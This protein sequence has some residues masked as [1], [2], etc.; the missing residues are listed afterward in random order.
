MDAR[1]YIIILGC[2]VLVAGCASNPEVV[3]DPLKSQIDTQVTFQEILQQPETFQGKLVVVGGEVLHAKRSTEATQLE[4]LQLP[5]DDS[6]RPSK[7]KTES[8]GRFLAFEQA[9]LDP[10]TF[11]P[12]TRV[13]VVGEVTG[14]QTAHLDEMTYQYPTLAIK[15]LHVWNTAE[16]EEIQGASGPWYGIFGGGST[17]GRVGGGVSIGVGF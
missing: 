13:T 4:I 14:S 12:G 1:L 3:P 9:F 15:H 16:A 17:G 2:C 6:N 8:Q 11:P 5:L 7:I 10:A